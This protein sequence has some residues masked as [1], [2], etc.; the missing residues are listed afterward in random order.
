[1]KPV[2]CAACGLPFEYNPN[3]PW[4]AGRCPRCSNQ[5]P[6][7]RLSPSQQ[8]EVWEKFQQMKKAQEPR[9]AL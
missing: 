9:S 7:A 5:G 8:A 2:A 4:A 3:W 6:L 1:M